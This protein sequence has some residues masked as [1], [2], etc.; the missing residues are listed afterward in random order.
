MQFLYPVNNN[1]SLFYF[2]C[3]HSVRI[4]FP[5]SHESKYYQQ[6][7][8]LV[9]HKTSLWLSRWLRYQTKSILVALKTQSMKSHWPGF[10][11]LV[12]QTKGLSTP[13]PSFEAMHCFIYGSRRIYRMIWPP[14]HRRLFLVCLIIKLMQD[15]QD[16]TCSWL[17]ILNVLRDEICISSCKRW[18]ISS[19]F[20]LFVKCTN[21]HRSTMNAST[22]HMI[23][24][25]SYQVITWNS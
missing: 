21:Y 1:L 15:R 2:F 4:Y 7:L 14:H 24:V 3:H 10:E 12:L 11:L 8:S 9:S 22:N 25:T 17:C 19:I 23:H 16:E 18:N 5:S 13:F 6:E 20:E